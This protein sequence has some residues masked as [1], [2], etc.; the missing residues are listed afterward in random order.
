MNGLAYHPDAIVPS[1]IPRDIHRSEIDEFESNGVVMLPKVFSMKWIEDLRKETE[2]AM[3]APG[4]FAE[5]YAKGA[6]RF[7][8][9]L[10]VARRHEGFARFVFESPAARIAGKIMGT[11]RVNFFYDQLLVKEPGTEE[12]TPWHQ[13]Q[14]YWA[15]G[16]RDVVS[17]WLPLDPIAADSSLRYVAGSHRWT[18]F[19]PQHFSDGSA[20]EG[21]G[22]PTLPDIDRN[23]ENYDI[24]SWDMEPGD[25]LLFQAMIVH[26]APGNLSPNRRRALATRWTGNDARYVVREGEQ[27]YPT[28][29]PGLTQGDPMTCQAFPLISLDD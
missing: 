25:C 8:G 10:D 7:F 11:S 19:N 18:E 3:D 26:G 28:F 1:P 6:G 16:G 5:E 23:A 12:R 9:D 13:D 17:I 20:Y 21:T 29:D 15:V 24:R 27:G 4:P 2:R 14:P 22:L